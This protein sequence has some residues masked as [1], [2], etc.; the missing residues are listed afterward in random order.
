MSKKYLSGTYVAKTD[1]GRVRI[2]NEDRAAA[3]INSRGNVLLVV[4]DGMGGQNKGDYAATLGIS[5]ITDAF[6]KKSR[7]L[8]RFDAFNWL[9][10]LVRKV[11]KYIY[12]ESTTSPTYKGMG[13]TLTLALILP[14][15][16]YTVQ[17][18]DSRCYSLRNRQLEQLTEDQSLVNYLYRTG[19]IKK[20]EMATH[21]KRHV[22]MNALGIYPS[23]EM[24][25]NRFRY[26]NETLLV[27]SDGLYN[28]VSEKDIASVLNGTDTI[29]EKARQLISFANKNGGSDNIAIVL[30]E[31]D[32]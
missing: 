32:K 26:N 1:I 28:N 6:Q 22:L 24:D 11:N 7:F 4:L 16:F 3:L 18:G 20:E 10:S 2:D 8:N 14:E 17:V 13:C 23:C 19:K 12:D 30:W 15:Y 27:C 5:F 29:D 31:A 9:N 21:P 25:I